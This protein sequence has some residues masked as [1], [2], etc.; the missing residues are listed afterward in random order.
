MYVERDYRDINAFSSIKGLYSWA[1]RITLND[2]SEALIK[3]HL[4]E[5]SVIKQSFKNLMK[6]VLK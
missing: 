4:K 5:L 1:T 6:D 2:L 3:G